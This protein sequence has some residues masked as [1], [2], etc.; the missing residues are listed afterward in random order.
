MSSK[1]PK[2][3]QNNPIWTQ[4]DHKWAHMSK[5]EWTE[6]N[7]NEIKLALMSSNFNKIFISDAHQCK[8]WHMLPLLKWRNKHQ[9]KRKKKTFLW[10]IFIRLL[11]HALLRQMKDFIKLHNSG[12]F[13]QDGSFGSHFRDLQKLA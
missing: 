13:L 4:N 1:D 8:T 7:L 12:K 10:L 9:K 11:G 2:Y 5:P 6:K 3:I